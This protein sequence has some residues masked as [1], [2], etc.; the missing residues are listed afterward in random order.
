[1]MR[2]MYGKEIPWEILSYSATLRQEK[3]CKYEAQ[4]QT[5]AGKGEAERVKQTLKDRRSNMSWRDSYSSPYLCSKNHHFVIYSIL[6]TA[7]MSIQLNAILS[8]KCHGRERNVTY[9]AF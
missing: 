9:F 1:M 8:A 2:N 4:K 5:F 6:S 3:N 7:L